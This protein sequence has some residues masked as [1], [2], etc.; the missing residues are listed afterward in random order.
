ML[1]GGH[2]G[3]LVALSDEGVAALARLTGE[4]ASSEA[5]RVLGRRLVAAG[6]AHPRFSRA[7]D[8]GGSIGRVTVVV[9]VRDRS[10][11]L[12]RCLA[13]LGDDY[14]VVVVDDG[15][16]DPAAVAAACRRR[17][18]RLLRRTT[19]GGPGVARN[20]AL[21]QIDTELVAL[22][23]S[24]CTVTKGWLPAL[25]RMFD[26]PAIGGVA[27]RV[28][29]RPRPDGRPVLARFA[30]AHS[31]LDMGGEQGE[32]GPGR[33]IRY[34]PSAA[35][36]VRRE[37]V[38]DRFDPA[39]RVGEDV[40]LVWRMSDAGWSVRLVPAVTVWHDEPTTWPAW[41][42]RRF[43][44]GTSA[45]PLA[46]RHPGRLAPVELRAWPSATVAA[47]LARRP[48]VAGALVL[49]AAGLTAR[50]VRRHGVPFGLTVRWSATS[51]GWTTV[52][53]GHALTTLA[54]PALLLGARRSR[55]GAFAAAVLVLA[56]PLVE[57]W[58]RRPAIDP[59]R[60]AVACIADDASYGAGVWVGCIRTRSLGP[61]TP[62]FRVRQ[63]DAAPDPVEPGHAGGELASSVAPDAAAVV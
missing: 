28:R 24:D 6:M 56:P 22:V 47:G 9:P 62:A 15:S 38:A 23:D 49:A 18:A 52:G 60:W 4:G 58:R 20:D 63:W 16:V 39:L 42:R 33:K 36:V 34:L 19:S 53:L 7:E 12:D 11:M 2:P 29:P 55:T 44:Y 61:L 1:I 26:D 51:A 25:V 8:S 57:W 35:L 45:G 59:V 48:A 46:R 10:A 41:L 30:D 27:P 13:S 17:G 5:D 54:W 40:D 31:P 43:R 21:E 37:A 3:R 50:S 32:V 14:P